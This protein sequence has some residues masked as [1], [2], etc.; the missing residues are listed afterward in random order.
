[1]P[2]GGESAELNW[3]QVLKGSTFMLSDPRGDVMGE[4]L[5]G[6]FHEDTRFLSRFMLTVEGDRPSLLSSGSGDYDTAAFFLTNSQLDGIAPR[7]FSVQ[8]YRFVGDGM[9]EVI[10]LQSH[11]NE[12]LDV[13]VRL[14]CG[15]DFADLFE[16]KREG[17]RKRGS[18]TTAHSPQHS[19]LLFHYEHEGFH[20]ASRVHTSERARVQGDDLVFDVHLEPR[21]A[22]K[23]RIQVGMKLGSIELAPVTE[24]E[25]AASMALAQWREGSQE[26]RKWRSEVPHLEAEWDQLNAVYNMSV[27]DLAALRLYAE[28]EGNEFSLPAAGLPWFM[29]IFGRDT[30]VTS[31]QSLLIGPELARGALKALAGLQGKE[32]NDFK[33][34]EPGKILHEIRFGELTV[35]GEMPHR[36]YYGTADATPL[37]LILLSEYWRLTGDDSTV[38]ELHSSALRALEWMDRYGDRDGDGYI[39]YGTRSSRGLRNQGW[40]DSWNSVCF[41]DGEVAEPPVAMC[42]IQGY[43][44]DAKIRCSELADRVWGDPQLALELRY[45]AE[46]LFDRFNADF[47]IDDRGGYY[48]EALVGEEPGSKRVV[49]AMTSDMG[50]LLWSGIVP[51]DRARLLVR[52]LFSDGMFSGWGI[53][54]MT[55]DDKA[56]NPIAYHNG[57]VWPHD[58]SL[59]SA[60]LQ[61]YGY[62]REAN[63]VA[64]AMLEAAGYSQFRLPEV[65]AG[66]RRADSGFPVRY[67]T[68]SSPQA[69]ATASPFLWLRLMLGLEPKEGTLALEPMLPGQVGRVE[70]RGLHAFGKRFDV[71]AEEDTGE[72][73]AAS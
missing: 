42:E 39:E 61:R 37:F 54:T 5:A 46:K 9:T 63:R 60:G 68:A 51:E 25:R 40:K 50:H 62:R 6:L 2:E 58:N 71:E 13:E 56:Y 27:S 45:E 22:W 57:T 33:D 48:G 44:Y 28:V 3:I 12:A 49:D 64:V 47:W 30:L 7:S 70:L 1:M 23:T 65:F 69:W 41:S 14:S 29:A 59:I 53:R 36:P 17:F 67:P 8:R 16:V 43:A 4:S 26:L 72:I 52:Q 73:T 34:E 20:A 38:M 66:Y 18:M 10:Q 21:G 32:V 15:A 24:V 11:V 55:A 19:Y 31:Y 35:I